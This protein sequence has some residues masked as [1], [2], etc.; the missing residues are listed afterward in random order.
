MIKFNHQTSRPF[1]PSVRFSSFL[2]D[3]ASFCPLLSV[4]I[5]FS[6]F[7]SVSIYFYFFLS[8]LSVFVRLCPFPSSFCPFLYVS[9]RFCPLLSVSIH[10]CLFWSVSIYFYFFLSDLSV[11]IRFCLFLSPFIRLCPFLSVSV[12]FYLFLTNWDFFG[13]GATIR[14][15]VHVKRFSVSRM[16][17]L[18]NSYCQCFSANAST[19]A[20]VRIIFL[21][22]FSLQGHGLERRPLPRNLLGC[23]RLPPPLHSGTDLLTQPRLPFLCSKAAAEQAEVVFLHQD[24]QVGGRRRPF[25]GEY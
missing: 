3:S 15:R 6:L 12:H 10:F 19:S 14:T 23:C 16:R 21:F 18:F 20:R 4:S 1:H 8:D 24:G 7:W 22:T 9:V 5:H 17:D 11:S 25:V 2:S 13:I